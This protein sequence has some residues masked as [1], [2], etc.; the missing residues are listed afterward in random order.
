MARISGWKVTILHKGEK[1]EGSEYIESARHLADEVA[2][3]ART[4]I[5][6]NEIRPF[7]DNDLRRFVARIFLY[8]RGVRQYEALIQVERM[9]LAEPFNILE[10]CLIEHLF[11]L[12]CLKFR[13][14]SEARLE[15]S[16]WA[17]RFYLANGSQKL[18]K[19]LS[20]DP[21]M[22]PMQKARA[23]K[24]ATEATEQAS[25]WR[26]KIV[27][28]AEQNRQE[29]PEFDSSNVH[30]STNKLIKVLREKGGWYERESIRRMY[31]TLMEDSGFAEVVARGYFPWKQL[32]EHDFA[33]LG[34]KSGHATGLGFP[35]FYERQGSQILIGYEIRDPGIHRT[36]MGPEIMLKMIESLDDVLVHDISPMCDLFFGRCVKIL[37]KTTGQAAGDVGS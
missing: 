9:G 32:V 30:N 24:I 2:A 22:P 33:G 35:D 1:G 15:A 5:Q 10:R 6:E 21:R 20:E 34:S 14:E 18:H 12:Y 19:E 23:Q 13:K 16:D 11:R 31:N 28:L 25:G 3:F 7:P 4:V 17:M 27:G 26:R 36:L 37:A 29:F 8:F